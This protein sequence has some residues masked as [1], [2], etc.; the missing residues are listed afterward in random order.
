MKKNI[1]IFLGI[2]LIVLGYYTFDYFS[3]DGEIEL[4]ATVQLPSEIK[5]YITG[6][7]VSPGV[8]TLEEG[9]RIEDLVTLAGG[10]TDKANINTINLAMRIDDGDKVVIPK[11]VES[12][13]ER[14]KDLNTM[15]VDDFMLIDTIGEVTA[16]KIIDY[17]QNKGFIVLE[18]L[19]EV[20]GIGEQKLQVI[21]RYLEN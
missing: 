6:E 14:V 15:T 5:T 12:E 17:R 18:D 2:C 11:I 13:N 19:M 10:F 20:D 1:L 21:K 9:S 16:K 4:G 8:Y 3:F 7:V